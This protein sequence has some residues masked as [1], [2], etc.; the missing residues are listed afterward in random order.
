MGKEAKE[1]FRLRGSIGNNSYHACIDE[2]AN[3]SEEASL[4][5]RWNNDR[6]RLPSQFAYLAF[7]TTACA[8][9]SSSSRA[10]SMLLG[11]RARA[12]LMRLN[13]KQISRD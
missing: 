8:D 12:Q 11:E 5:M 6:L 4:Q 3:A 7:T 1:K 2:E 13:L 9:S 10:Q